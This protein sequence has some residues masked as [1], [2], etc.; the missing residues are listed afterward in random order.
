M[1]DRRFTDHALLQHFVRSGV[2]LRTDIF[3]IATD[4][5]LPPVLRARYAK[6]AGI[7]LIEAFVPVWDV[8]MDERARDLIAGEEM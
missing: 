5:K 8:E 7:P 6:A 4:F 1:R 2:G 3:G